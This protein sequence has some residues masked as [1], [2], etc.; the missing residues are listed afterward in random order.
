MIKP[1][2]SNIIVAVSGSEASVQAAKYAIVFAKLYKCK[3][4]A[5][6]VVDLATLKQ[7]TMSR[8][9]LA[10]ESAGF[11]LNL[12]ENGRRYL[13]FVDD[14]AKA[15]GVKLETELRRGSV[16]SEILAAAE[17]KKADVIVLGGWEKG[18][19]PRD[20]ISHLHR[21]VMLNAKCSVLITKERDTDIIY[22]HI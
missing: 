1:L 14:L 9:L 8:I 18:R 21:E 15:K 3:L 16:C 19:N 13:A 2:V 4:T 11:E 7:L 10:D 12:D 6:Y 20:I 5:V 22:R 17:E